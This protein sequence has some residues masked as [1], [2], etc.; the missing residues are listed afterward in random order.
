MKKKLLILPILTIIFIFTLLPISYLNAKPGNLVQNGNFE[1]SGG[2]LDYW[3]RT[4]DYWIIENNLGNNYAKLIINNRHHEDLYQ[5]I[6]TSNPNVNFSYKIWI[7]EFNS[8]S[9]IR[10]SI[11]GY[12]NITNVFQINEDYTGTTGTFL[13]KGYNILQKWKDLN[14][15]TSIPAF[16][17]IQLLV[18]VDAPL[19]MSQS[20][21]VMV[22]DFS[23]APPA[24]APK[25]TKTV[26]APEKKAEVEPVWIRT[27]VMTCYQVWV[28]S[29]NKFEMVFWYPY[30][31][32]NWVKIYDMSGKEVYSINM[33]LDYPHIVVDLP[34]GM[35]TV[36]TFTI[37]RTD[38]IQTFL[39]GKDANTPHQDGG[40]R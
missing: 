38:P 32:N 5:W 6:N 18:S 8:A 36:K 11:N 2:S 30:R 26:E 4:N 3:T 14:P 9:A 28:N 35:Y 20:D 22:D 16:D 33:P 12:Q 25:K 19:S 29:D 10:V 24:S 23:L 34:N 17:R 1:T 13:E 40:I 37:G 21:T 15:G 7:S 39:V 31:D 27:M